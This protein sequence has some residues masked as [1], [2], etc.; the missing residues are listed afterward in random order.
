ML[1]PNTNLELSVTNR[2]Q[3]TLELLMLR[4][5]LTVKDMVHPGPSEEQLKQILEIGSRVPDHKKQVPWRFLTFEKN[6]RKKFGKILRAI[7]AKNYPKTNEK[8]LD[9][10]ENRFLR[11]PLVIAVISTADKDNPK[12]PEWE[13]ILTAGAVCQNILIASNAMGYASQWLTEWYAYD[14][15]VLKE[16]NLNPNERIAGFIYIGTASKQPKERGRP[17]LAN[18]VKKWE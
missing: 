13:Q 3:E 18:L 1:G 16:L 9:F 6:T 12:V 5:S 10:E 14:K 8:M 17:D 11:A 2:S 7:F 15:V 4:R